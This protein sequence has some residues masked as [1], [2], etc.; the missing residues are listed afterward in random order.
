MTTVIVEENTTTVTVVDE[1]NLIVQVGIQGPPGTH[2]EVPFSWANPIAPIRLT[3]I[4]AGK[5]IYDVNLIITE[6]FNGS[7]NIISIGTIDLPEGLMGIAENDPANIGSYLAAPC[8]K[9][10]IDTDVY[11]YIT[12]GVGLS[13]GAGLVVLSIQN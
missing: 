9:Y 11:L 13:Q 1:T 5:I 4:L 3:T 6:A 10:G 7:G 12:E 2:I 8:L